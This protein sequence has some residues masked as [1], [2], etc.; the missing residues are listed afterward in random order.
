MFKYAV[1]YIKPAFYHYVFIPDVQLHSTHILI[2]GIS[3]G[4]ISKGGTVPW[5][6][7]MPWFHVQS[8]FI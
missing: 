2:G 8:L 4:Q 6:L 3:G 1:Y 7:L 5:P